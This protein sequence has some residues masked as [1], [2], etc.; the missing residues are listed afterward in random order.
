[1]LSKN[2]SAASARLEHSKTRPTSFLLF[3]GGVRGG[4]G[5]GKPRSRGGHI[6][7]GSPGGPPV[8]SPRVKLSDGRHLAYRELGVPKEE[9]KH[10][11]IVIHGFL[12]SKDLSLPVAQ[13]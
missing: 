6:F 10:K 5:R 2:L 1:W 8:T 3:S 7:C 13:V 11:I 4:K 9:A 12:S